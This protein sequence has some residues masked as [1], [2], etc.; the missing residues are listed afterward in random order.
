MER[1]IYHGI[2]LMSCAL[3]LTFVAIKASGQESPQ[4]QAGCAYLDKEKPSLFIS[5]E[6]ELTEKSNKG[7]P[8]GWVLLRLH[9]NSSC[10]I[11]VE[12]GDM[13]GDETLFKKE[14]RKMPNGE[15]G[16][17]YIPDPPEGA[18]LSICYDIQSSKTAAPKPA[19][20]LKYGDIAYTYTVPPGRSVTFV[21]DPKYFKKRYIISIPYSYSWE[22]I[23]ER[24]VWGSILHR[25][26]YFYE[27]PG[28]FFQG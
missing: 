24:N 16:T 14:V 21:V 2:R 5:Y 11:I 13:S 7:R 28:G 19:N 15:V 6:R 1:A 10:S 17:A 26:L 12:T 9:N 25:V 4:G 18:R 23:T 20:Y 3:I 22:E 8:V 27:M